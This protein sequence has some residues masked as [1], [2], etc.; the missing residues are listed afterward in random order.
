MSQGEFVNFVG[1][2]TE[3]AECAL[4]HGELARKPC[5]RVAKCPMGQI[6]LSHGNLTLWFSPEEFREFRRLIVKARQ[7]LADA[8]P[9]ATLGLP[10]VPPDG[11]AFGIN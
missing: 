2:V 11:G 1:L 3:A 9:L 10:W 4:R 5:G 8:E 7:Q 6:M